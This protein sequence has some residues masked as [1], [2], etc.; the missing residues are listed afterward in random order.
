[1]ASK[2]E[3]KVINNMITSFNFE[4]GNKVANLVEDPQFVLL[5]FLQ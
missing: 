4:R 1:M 2:A 5:F 3:H